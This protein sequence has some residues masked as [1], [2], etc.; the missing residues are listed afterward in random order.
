M[1]LTYIDVRAKLLKDQMNIYM[2]QITFLS[3]NI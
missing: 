3:G 1:N 2:L